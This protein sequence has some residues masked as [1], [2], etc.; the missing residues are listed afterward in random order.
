MT[1]IYELKTF[2]TKLKIFGETFVKNNSKNCIIEIDGIER[3]ICE[4]L[5]LD[6]DLQKNRTIKIKL[7]EIRTITDMSFMF[8]GKDIP[9]L[10]IDISWD[11]KNII[12]MSRMFKLS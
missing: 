6:K 7:K 8:C 5:E 10:S 4:N 2:Y 9:I 11:T 3:E 1:I 12:N